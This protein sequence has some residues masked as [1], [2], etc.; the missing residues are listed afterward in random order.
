MSDAATYVGLMNE[1]VESP[2]DCDLALIARLRQGD[3]AAMKELIHRFGP[4]LNR[5]V[6]RLTAWNSDR[7]DILQEVFLTAWQQA[8]SFRG[9]GS[10]AGWLRRLAINQCLNHRRARNAFGRMLARLA[11]R[12]SKTQNDNASGWDRGQ[13]VC[14]AL[15]KLRN[16]DRTVLVLYYLEELSGD[17]VA[18]ALGVRLET[19]HVRLHR[20]RQRLREL[21][22]EK[23]QCDE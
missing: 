11:G 14:D 8:G 18:E 16:E 3:A 10:L 21:L 23:E 20:A 9:D 15:A 4:R 17:E 7:E 22:S 19:M 13:Q 6:G 2:H 5:L 1:G 12:T